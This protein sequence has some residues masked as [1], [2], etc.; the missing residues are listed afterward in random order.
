MQDN[1]KN[2]NFKTTEDTASVKLFSSTS[3]AL[4]TRNA[5]LKKNLIKSHL[6]RKF[7]KKEILKFE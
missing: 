4:S 2:L 3:S 6:V 5:Y 1:L 7:S